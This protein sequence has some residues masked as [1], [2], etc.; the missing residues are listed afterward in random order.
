MIHSLHTDIFT[1]ILALGMFCQVTN[2]QAELL[3]TPTVASFELLPF[4]SAG[5]R[6]L[7][8]IAA[9]REPCS[10]SAGR[11]TVYFFGNFGWFCLEGWNGNRWYGLQIRS[12]CE[13]EV[14]IVKIW[15]KG[16][17]WSLIDLVVSWDRGYY[18]ELIA[19]YRQVRGIEVRPVV[20]EYGSEVPAGGLR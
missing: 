7:I 11:S 5:P 2:W 13:Q 1:S 19:V 9:V 8:P 3:N 17:L 4:F 10:R 12:W 16:F 18:C 14:L 6:L 20:R 15:L